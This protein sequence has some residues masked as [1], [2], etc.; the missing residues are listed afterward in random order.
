MRCI[1][2]GEDLD[3]RLVVPTACSGNTLR[4][5]LRRTQQL[6]PTLQKPEFESGI[7]ADETFMI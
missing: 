3:F 2:A 6:E 5:L 1:F 4:I 7:D